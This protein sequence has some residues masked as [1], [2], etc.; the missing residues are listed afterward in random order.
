M[1]NIYDIVEVEIPITL[2]VIT[3][4][5]RNVQSEIDINLNVVAHKRIEECHGFHILYD[6]DETDLEIKIREYLENLTNEKATQ[7][8]FDN[9]ILEENERVMEIIIP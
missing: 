9:E 4:T 3:S 2:K 5:G 7:L 1:K 8:L 6:A